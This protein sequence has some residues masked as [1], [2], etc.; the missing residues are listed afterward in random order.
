MSDNTGTLRNVTIEGI[1]YRAA[2]DTNVTFTVSRFENSVV[3]TTG[4][5]MKKKIRRV[6]VMENV[7]LVCNPNEIDQLRVFAE[8]LNDLKFAVTLADGSLYRAEGSIEIEN[9]ET[10]EN[11]VT[12]Q[13]LPVEDW[14]PFIAS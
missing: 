4:R 9:V 1:S 13:L 2:A 6:P 7:T 5:G 11:R 10:E 14:T 8:S 12:C 3:P